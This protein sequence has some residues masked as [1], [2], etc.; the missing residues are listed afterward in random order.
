MRLSPSLFLVALA[1]PAGT[2]SAQTAPAVA[3]AA[4]TITPA[5]VARH[6]GVIA[7]DSMM[8]RNTP[9]PGLEMTAQY[10][11]AQFKKFG[12]KPGGDNGGWLQRYPL[13]KDSTATAP[14]TV[15][16][17][18][19][20]DPKLKH[21]Y[22][23]LSAHMDH[24]GV[25]GGQADSIF[26]GADDDASGTAGI[27]ELAE[28][29]SQPGARPRRSLIFITVSGE[30]KG[31][32]GSNY[33]AT[34]PPVPLQQIVANVNFDMIG[35]WTTDTVLV[36]GLE[37]SDLG[38]TFDRVNGSHPE[39]KLVAIPNPPA[40]R[41]YSSD[42]YSFARRGVPIIK[43]GGPSEG[44][45]DYHKVTDSPEKIET[46]REARILRFAFYLGQEVANAEQRPQWKPESYKSIVKE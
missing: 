39:T 13:P 32:W 34:H 21:E 22:I 44:N 40:R 36:I 9:S 11:A 24:V 20:S 31:M 7:A 4:E 3:K 27:L 30:E 17:L 2:L 16:M 10:V 28:A 35:R 26:N 25:R 5:D 1:L 8:G 15:G 23:V 46:E 18:E 42:H 19:G 6:I 43:F 14:N 12:L 45:V 38:A 29:F 37:H 33:F 41:L